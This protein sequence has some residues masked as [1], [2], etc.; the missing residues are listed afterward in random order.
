MHIQLVSRPEF[1]ID[2]K[3]FSS[4]CRDGRSMALIGLLLWNATALQSLKGKN[5]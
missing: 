1:P 3:A 2:V 4:C 5:A